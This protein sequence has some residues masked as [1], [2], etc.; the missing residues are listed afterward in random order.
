[1]H[2]NTS[3]NFKRMKTK[4]YT[5]SKN[6]TLKRLSLFCG[7]LLSLIVVNAQTFNVQVGNGTGTSSNNPISSCYGYTYS[8]QIYMAADISAAGGVP[9]LIYKIRFYYISGPNTNSRNWT[10]YMGNSFKS[11]FASNTDWEPLANLNQVYTGNVTFPAANNWLEITLNTPFLWDGISNIVVAVDENQINYDC[12]INWQVTG[13]QFNTSIYY[14][15]DVTNPDPAAPPTANSRAL[16]APNIQFEFQQTPCAGLTPAPGNT[17]AS[18][19]SLCLVPNNTTILS[20]QNNYGVNS[21][22]SYQWQENTGSGWTDIAGATAI[23]YA[24]NGLANNVDYRCRVGCDNTNFGTSSPVT[25]SV[26]PLPTV[27]ISPLVSTLCSGEQVN[28]VAIGAN[29]FV[30]SPAGGL[31]ATTGSSVQ[32]APATNQVYTV[33]GTNTSTGCSNTATAVVSPIELFQINTLS[34]PSP[35]CEAGNPVTIDVSTI[36]DYV[37]GFGVMEYQ[38]LDSSGLILQDWSTNPSYSF[39]PATE[40]VYD[41]DVKARSTAC[42]QTP[43]TKRIQITVGF[44]GTMSITHI[45]CHTPT[46][47]ILVGDAFGQTSANNWYSNDFSSATILP[48]E[49]TLHQNASISGGKLILTPSAGSQRGGFTVLNPNS[50]PGTDVS[51]DIYFTLTADQPQNNFGTGGAD[52]IAYSFG[53][54]ADYTLNGSE[55]CSGYGS[56]LRVSFDAADNSTQNG[57]TTGIYVTYGFAGTNQIGPAQATTLAYTTDVSRW[58]LKTDVPVNIHI[59][60][61]G[62]LSL[63]VDGILVFSDIQLP[64]SFQTADK[65]NWKHVFSAHTGGDAMR[66]GID[67]L[68]INYSALN[69]GISPGNSGSLPSAWQQTENFTGLA[70]GDYDVYLS[71]PGNELCHT[72]LGTYSILDLNPVVNFPSDTI[73]CPGETILLDAGNPGSFYEWNTGAIGTD[74][75]FL[76]VTQQGTYLVEVT[77]PAGC[78]AFGIVSVSD[79]QSPVVNLGSDTAICAGTQL[80]LDAGTDG[81]V[82]LWND[83]STNQTLSVDEAGIYTATV[84]NPDGC[85]SSDQIAVTLLNAPSVDGI[86]TSING[87]TVSFSAQNAQHATSFDWNFGDGNTINTTTASVNYNYVNCGTY[88]VTLTAE[89]TNN[90]GTDLATTDIEIECVGIEELNTEN[91]IY[92]YPNPASDFILLGNP[93]G[94]S[95]ESLSI[96]DTG[97]RQLFHSSNANTLIPDISFWSP[98]FY[99]VKIE[100]G[101]KRFTQRLIIQR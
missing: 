91:G 82:Y 7:F 97:G 81:T 57:N 52:G 54:D 74:E 33:T 51:Y 4:D 87:P 56:K 63:M 60:R 3:P 84:T 10:V 27:S 101:G 95:I 36:P 32:A 78:L 88:T 66:Q 39:T 23:S 42:A 46:G 69:Y 53:D 34:S 55:P 30:W 90:C 22:I 26:N 21:G 85:S 37:A 41:I 13:T 100:S 14:R 61:N 93:A 67:D 92:L 38:W 49:A 11:Q 80:L 6:K 99:L 24:A 76:T 20:L 68:V 94:L 2:H 62:K 73:L 18:Q 86:N 35:I 19:T 5:C 1:M 72:F 25:I 58:K 65:S 98:G 77:D 17:L 45:D 43:P 48:N 71:Q 70:A 64:Q 75:Q 28:L 44:G 59:T 89:N 47:T 31:S 50:I 15:S 9:A 12:T 40:G 16:S 96:Y 8:Q 29:E 79:G 83:N